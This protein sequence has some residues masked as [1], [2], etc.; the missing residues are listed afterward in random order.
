[1]KRLIEWV[2]DFTELVRALTE[3]IPQLEV[4]TIKVVSWI[5]WIAILIYILN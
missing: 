2:K 1:M 4:L 5:G 3:L